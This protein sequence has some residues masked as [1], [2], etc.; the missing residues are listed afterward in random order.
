METAGHVRPVW[1]EADEEVFWGY[2]QRKNSLGSGTAA[3]VLRDKSGGF[4]QL[5]K[6]KSTR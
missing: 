3:E 5:K 6:E 4:G 1:A 2:L